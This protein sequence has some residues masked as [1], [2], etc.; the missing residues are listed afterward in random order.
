MR[1]N[2][3]KMGIARGVHPRERKCYKKAKKIWSQK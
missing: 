1:E 3:R 2:F